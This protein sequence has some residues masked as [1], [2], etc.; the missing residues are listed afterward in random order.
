MSNLFMI[1]C[2]T[3]GLTFYLVYNYPFIMFFYLAT[4]FI[5]SQG[6]VFVTEQEK[7]DLNYFMAFYLV[8]LLSPF[9]IWFTL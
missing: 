6:I 9:I 2:L 8:C 3:L 4:S 5:F 7:K 1:F